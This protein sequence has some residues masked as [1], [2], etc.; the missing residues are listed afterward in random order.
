M[1]LSQAVRSSVFL[2][3]RLP[4]CFDLR[5]KAACKNRL[6]LRAKVWW[7]NLLVSRLKW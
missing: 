7:D 4:E 2:W 1:R 5:I 6:E 3:N